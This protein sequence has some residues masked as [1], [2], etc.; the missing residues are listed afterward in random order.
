[1]IQVL[2]WSKQKPYR[3]LVGKFKCIQILIKDLSQTNRNTL[4]RSPR[5]LSDFNMD[6]N[7]DFEENSPHQV[8]LIPE[9]Y[10]RPSKSYFQEPQELVSL[11]NTGKVVQKFLLQQ[12]DIDEILKIIQRKVLKGTHLHVTVKEIQA[13]YSVSPYFKIYICNYLKISCLAQGQQFCKVETLAEKYILLHT[14][15]FK[16]VTT[17]EKETALIAISEGC[18]DNIITLYNLCLFTGHQGVIKHV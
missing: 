5:N 18:A 13:G 9:T 16:L 6:I 17:S 11:I 1:M 12:A 8:G 3:I 2:E 4:T 14:L 10:Q 15:L 7:T